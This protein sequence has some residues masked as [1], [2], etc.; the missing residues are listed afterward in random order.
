MAC[1]EDAKRRDIA[2]AVAQKRKQDTSSNFP[3]FKWE[4]M[5]RVCGASEIGSEPQSRSFR[6]S[7]NRRWARALGQPRE[8]MLPRHPRRAHLTATSPPFS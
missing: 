5:K 3:F 1:G 6:W 2:D 8:L 4:D 7:R